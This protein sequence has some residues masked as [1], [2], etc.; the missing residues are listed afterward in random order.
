MPVS[1]SDGMPVTIG[2]GGQRTIFVPW[3]CE[4][5]KNGKAHG[6]ENMPWL[7]ALGDVILSPSADPSS[8]GKNPCIMRRNCRDP[9]SVSRRTQGDSMGTFAE[10]NKPVS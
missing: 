3:G 7:P 8:D 6:M 10:I 9:S 1:D 5:I 2:G 4:R